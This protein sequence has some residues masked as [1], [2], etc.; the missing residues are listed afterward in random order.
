M[1]DP[2]KNNEPD[3]N[4]AKLNVADP[5]DLAG[6][7]AIGTTYTPSSGPLPTVETSSVSEVVA[8][9]ATVAV[10]AATTG[11]SSAGTQDAVKALAHGLTQLAEA[12]LRKTGVLGS[13][14]ASTFGSEAE[15]EI[16]F[17][18][19]HIASGVSQLMTHIGVAVPAEIASIKTWFAERF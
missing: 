1:V 12:A 6:A 18:L 2:N 8:S 7:G 10:D 4:N 17:A 16:T 5:A 3:P 15:K 14:A 9:A 11:G 13:I 19:S